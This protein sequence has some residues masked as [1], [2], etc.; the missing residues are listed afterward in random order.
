MIRVGLANQS[1]TV[2][3]E[4]VKRVAAALDVQVKRDLK[5]VWGVDAEVVALGDPRNIPS[6]VS[7]IIIVDR[8]PGDFAGVHTI[9]QGVPWAMVSTKRDWALA[10]SHECVELLV[11]PSGEATHSSIGLALVDGAVRETAEAFD[12]LLEACDP[13]EDTDHAYDIGGI[14]VSDFYTPHYFDAAVRA[15]V[16]YSFNG[17]L[18]RP[19][20][21]RPN[22]YLSWRH[23]ETKRLQQLR[24][25]RGFE[26]VDLPERGADAGVTTTTRMFVD[27]N[28]PTPRTHPEQFARR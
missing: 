28:T 12:Y 11:D 1:S 3:A 17:A 21:V 7:P 18:T 20:E 5:P 8:T 2:T 24:N 26:I 23:P 22:G 25:F 19:R 10:A 4:Q 27:M 6:G 16:R 15:G 13:I 14:R 9:T